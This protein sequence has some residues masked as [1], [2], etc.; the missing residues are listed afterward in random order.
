MVRQSVDE[1]KPWDPLVTAHHAHIL[2]MFAVGHADPIRV[3]QCQA[4]LLA[5]AVDI[6]EPDAS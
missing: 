1:F 4:P 6:V 5:S 3:A 2:S